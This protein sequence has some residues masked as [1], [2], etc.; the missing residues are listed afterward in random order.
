MLIDC[1]IVFQDTC[2]FC[3]NLKKFAKNCYNSDPW[4]SNSMHVNN[5]NYE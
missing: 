3:Q 5:N 2:Y 4:V 1:N